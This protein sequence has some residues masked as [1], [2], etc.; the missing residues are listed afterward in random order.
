MESKEISI[1]ECVSEALD[2]Y[3]NNFFLVLVTTAIAMIGSGITIGILAGPL[4]VGLFLIFLKLYDMRQAGVDTPKPEIGDLFQGFDKFKESFLFVLGFILVSIIVN[5]LTSLLPAIGGIAS[6]AGGVAVAT[7][8]MFAIPL[9]A[10][11]GMTAMDAAK[12]SLESSKQNFLQ[13]ALLVLIGQLAASVGAFLFGIGLF[14]TAP[15]YLLIVAVA[16]RKYC[17]STPMTL[18]ASSETSTEADE[19]GDAARMRKVN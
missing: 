17:S 5:A 2:L 15:I 3:K 18:T 13:F 4:L 8:A 7:A 12:Q 19:D 1:K 14:L 6:F 16:Y 9:I 10:E 11:K